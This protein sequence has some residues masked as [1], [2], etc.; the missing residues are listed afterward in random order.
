MITINL[1]CPD[2]KIV[3][4]LTRL[5]TVLIM[6]VVRIWLSVS[7]IVI[8]FIFHFFLPVI[9]LHVLHFAFDTSSNKLH[10]DVLIYC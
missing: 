9:S 1:L 8:C 7:V 6:L 10:V 2:I 5:H 3:I 4:P